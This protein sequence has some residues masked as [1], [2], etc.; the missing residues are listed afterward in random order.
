MLL[1]TTSS[2]KDDRGIQRGNKA[3]ARQWSM[4]INQWQSLSID[5]SISMP[6]MST[7]SYFT[8]GLMMNRVS[9]DNTFPA[10]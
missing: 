8:L 10:P 9:H 2:V 6:Y 3:T 7:P 4:A 5:K 1:T